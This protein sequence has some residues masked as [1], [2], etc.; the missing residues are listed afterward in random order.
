MGPHIV[1][2]KLIKHSLLENP[3][4]IQIIFPAWNLHLV[5]RFQKASEARLIA[6][7]HPVASHKSLILCIL[8]VFQYA[9][10]QKQSADKALLQWSSED[11][12]DPEIMVQREG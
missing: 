5:Q 3:P 2:I 7:I 1:A 8:I 11:V 10:Y 9:N 12:H 6:G 4:W